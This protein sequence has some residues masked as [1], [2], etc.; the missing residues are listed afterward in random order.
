MDA[1][2]QAVSALA[3]FG[4][5]LSMGY[6]G[7]TPPRTEQ[8]TTVLLGVL[9]FLIGLELGGRRDLGRRDLL[10]GVF[11]A[12]STIA[13]STIAGLLLGVVLDLDVRLSAAVGGGC[14]WYTLT[15]PMLAEIG[16]AYWGYLGFTSNLAREIIVI[17]LYPLL[18]RRLEFAGIAAG[19]A[20]TMDTSLGVIAARGR[21]LGVIAFAHGAI[22]TLLLPIILPLIAGLPG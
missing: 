9:V 3:V 4:V 5:G 1:A 13:M 2:K 19:G 8:I 14:G 22:I 18:P 16:G 7:I 15:G 20:T 17:A 11:L 12:I 10:A 6:F 21:S